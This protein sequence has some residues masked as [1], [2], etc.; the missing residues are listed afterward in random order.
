VD[1]D[2]D[3]DGDVDIDADNDG[4]GD[5]DVDGDA[6]GDGDGDGDF[7]ADADGDFDIDIEE[8]GAVCGDD[9]CSL[10]ETVGSCPEDC[11]GSP[12]WRDAA[13]MTG[14]RQVHTA[15]PLESGNVL[16][17]GGADGGPPRLAS[18]VTCL[19]SG[20]VLVVGGYNEGSL[21]SAE[22]FGLE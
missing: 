4:D 13:S 7:E 9:E 21:S 14:R 15:T 22:I 5:G 2:V 1:G 20:E 3:N 10:G 8:E 11:E 19:A 6:D 18:T 12:T 16:V 17:V